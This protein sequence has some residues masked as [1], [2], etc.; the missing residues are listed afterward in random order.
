MILTNKLL[1]NKQLVSNE[2]EKFEFDGNKYYKVYL[3]G[4][5][6]YENNLF[7]KSFEEVY[8]RVADTRYIICV[9]RKNK[10]SKDS[11]FNVPS[12]FDYDKKMQVFF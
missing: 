12:I 6:I 8:N 7:I 4:A 5:T 10:I 11:Y 2:I 3:K 1:T 9:Q